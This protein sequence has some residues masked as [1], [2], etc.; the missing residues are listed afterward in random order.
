[1]NER[2]ASVRRLFSRLAPHY[3]LLN[4]VLTGGLHFLWR[5]VAVAAVP[6]SPGSLVLDVCAGAGD[7]AVALRRR[8]ASVVAVDL[9]EPM[10]ATARRRTGGE[11]PVVVG[12]VLELPFADA[13]FTAATVGFGLR[14]SESDLPRFL[15]EVRRVLRP[16]GTCVILELSHPPSPLWNRLT[17]LYVHHLVPLIGA[18]A[19]AEAYRYLSRSL[20][21]YPDA[22]A[23]RR[24]LLEAGFAACQY[25]LL[26]G[27]VVAVHV[28]T[29]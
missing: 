15:G 27:G 26:T 9:A 22:P 16:D 12:N 4:T 1:M 11:V 14:H 17:G 6:V 20:I 24:M 2:E 19:D 7:F 13:A 23:L 29:A 5:R 21:G 3:A 28:A 8:G 25:R 10:L 18:F